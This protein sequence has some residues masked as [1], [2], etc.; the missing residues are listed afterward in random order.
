M[1]LTLL[2]A[3]S[4]MEL[5]VEQLPAGD[6]I[7]LVQDPRADIVTMAVRF[8]VGDFSPAWQEAHLDEI[9]SFQFYDPEGELRQRAEALAADVDV[10]INS[11]N[12]T[13][14]ATCLREDMR[15]CAELLGE[16]LHTTRLDKDELKRA[17]K[18]QKA[19][20]KGRLTDPEFVLRQ[21]AERALYAEGDPRRDDV[22]KPRRIDVGAARDASAK[23]Q[24]LSQPGRLL[25]F[26]GNLSMAEAQELS[27]LFRLPQPTEPAPEWTVQ[28]PPVQL[29]E[30]AT[31]EVE[32]PDLTQI[33]F[34]MFRPG[35]T[36]ADEN[37]PHQYI[38]H[39][40]LTGHF[41]SRMGR[42][43][44][45]DSGLTYG[46]SGSNWL[47]NTEPCY[48]IGSYSK[49]ET[50]EEAIEVMRQTMATYAAEGITEQEREQAVS[51]LLG[52]HAVSNPAPWNLMWDHV[53]E[54]QFGWEREHYG[55]LKRAAAELSLEQV[56]AWIAEFYDP[57][58]W[59]LVVLRPEQ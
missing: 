23:T 18:G 13:I 5:Q 37:I 45:H 30:P 15:G 34:A 22:E 52:R 56:N 1:L 57:T 59:S 41:Y 39:H 11:R 20:W 49:L 54:L 26:S 32:L 16:T 51:Y 3:A 46:V 42:A 33:Y 58:Q 35:L 4:A 48:R 40:V 21:A 38:A 6:H 8:P 14:S 10:D 24:V 31:V 28:V 43:L 25:G 9:W 55:Q 17:R 27:A 50:G 53:A 44:R 2:T 12:A 29:Q 47:G 7:V 36:H 19:D